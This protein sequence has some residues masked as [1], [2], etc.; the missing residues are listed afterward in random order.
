M[1]AGVWR[2]LLT[3]IAVAAMLQGCGTGSGGALARGMD[4]GDPIPD[5][6]NVAPRN[7]A[8]KFI[9]NAYL[10]TWGSASRAGAAA[11]IEEGL[12]EG[13]R[14]AGHNLSEAEILRY[15]YG[16]LPESE[17]W[18]AAFDVAP[19]ELFAS[20]AR[21]LPELGYSIAVASESGGLIITELVYRPP[22]TLEWGGQILMTAP[23]RWKDRYFIVVEPMPDRRTAVR[24]RREVRISRRQ[25]G[26]WSD[27]ILETSSGHNEAVIL[28]RIAGQAP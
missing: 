1:R 25:D 27:F 11:G 9:T 18:C 26:G 23:N 17:T 20:V 14:E 6:R 13:L 19:V 10:T 7:G 4:G 8:D 2:G 3:P 5:C 22:R 12:R 24:V 21:L 15:A 16:W 28:N